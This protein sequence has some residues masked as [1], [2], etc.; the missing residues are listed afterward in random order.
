MRARLNAGIYIRWDDRSSSEGGQV[1]GDDVPAR[2][3]RIGDDAERF[4]GGDARGG[5]VDGSDLRSV[6][7]GF[8]CVV[9]GSG[10]GYGHS[11]L[12]AV[13]GRPDQRDA[14]LRAPFRQHLPGFGGIGALQDDRASGEHVD[15]LF[16]NG[17]GMGLGHGR[18]V[19]SERPLR[20]YDGFRAHVAGS[21]D[22]LAVDVRDLRHRGVAQD[23]VHHP[24]F[25]QGC[26]RVHA[27][28]SAS[29]DSHTSS[30]DPLLSLLA[31]DGHLPL[32]PA[33]NLPS[34]SSAMSVRAV[35]TVASRTSALP[36]SN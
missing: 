12:G 31:H 15:R 4:I 16:G 13:G 1:D 14:V 36:P 8:G 23:E 26:Q 24:G 10:D 11:D 33:H 22:E 28:A 20:R 5:L 2:G 9:V 21:V 32:E 35:L 18:I 6:R 30:D 27:D 25:H 3:R 19:E 29:R 17:L 7:D 34:R